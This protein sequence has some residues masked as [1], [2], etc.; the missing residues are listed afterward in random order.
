METRV[1][2]APL[3]RLFED[4]L[5]F[6]TMTLINKIGKSDAQLLPKTMLH[7]NLWEQKQLEIRPRF[8]APPALRA[9][10]LR[11][12]RRG[13]S[14]V[15]DSLG[16]AWSHRGRIG[17]GDPEQSRAEKGQSEPISREGR[18]LPVRLSR[19]AATPPT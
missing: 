1:S 2:K 7:E 18:V 16:E 4:T 9:N 10:R 13:G 12:P 17:I 11:W 8:S 19:E 14:N 3:Q 15:I 5:Y 6:P